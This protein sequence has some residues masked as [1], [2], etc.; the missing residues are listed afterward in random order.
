MS[1]SRPSRVQDLV[2]AV[3]VSTSAALAGCR[4]GSEAASLDAAAAGAPSALELTITALA[5]GL[6]SLSAAPTRLTAASATG[7]FTPSASI[8]QAA[9]AAGESVDVGTIALAAASV[10]VDKTTACT[11]D[12]LK[13]GISNLACAGH[14][15][16]K[17]TA[18]TPPAQSV[19]TTTPPTPSADVC[20]GNPADAT[21]AAKYRPAVTL[22]PGSYRSDL[23]G[24]GQMGMRIALRAAADD[25]AKVVSVRYVLH[26]SY[27]APL[28]ASS[29]D[30]RFSAAFSTWSEA[31]WT[32]RCA[33]VELVG[34]QKIVVAGAATP[35]WH[36]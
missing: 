31:S 34:S 20:Q 28:L 25:A 2:I 1:F 5:G 10:I 16:A 22:I 23:A 17:P 30:D 3:A 9:L 29:P 32:T 33:V 21:L 8:D 36:R 13:D 12:A 26:D 7:A 19:G 14:G 35:A 4:V 11:T 24:G 27:E 6:F 15:D 18:D